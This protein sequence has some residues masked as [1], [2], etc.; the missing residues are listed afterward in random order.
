MGPRNY[1]NLKNSG[2]HIQIQTQTYSVT[3]NNLLNILELN[4]LIYKMETT[5]THLTGLL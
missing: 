1:G 3:M 2:K 5:P 4:F